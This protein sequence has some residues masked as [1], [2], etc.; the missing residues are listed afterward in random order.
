MGRTE[1]VALIEALQ[2]ARGGS[3]VIVYLTNTRDGIEANMA[4]DVVPQI[5]RH[6]QAAGVTK[7]SS[8]VD[9]V[10]HS[11]GG[12]GVVPWR[13]VSL[14]RE[15]AAEFTVLVPNRAYSAATLTA[16]G[17]DTVLMHPMGMLGPI[18]PTVGTVFNP[19]NPDNPSQKLGISVED[20]SSY[21]A[22][23]RD[24]VGIRH[25]EELVQAFKLLAEKVHPLALGTV[26]RST[27][28]SRMLAERLMRSRKN[29][30][31]VD[32]HSIT[33][34]IEK[35]TSKLYFHGHPIHRGEARDELKLPYVLDAPDNVADA[36][37]ALFEAYS[38]EL[39][40]E[41]QFNPFDEATGG[42][43][44]I[45]LPTPPS[46][47]PN[48]QMV[49]SIPNVHRAAIGPVPHALVESVARS[50]RF[51]VSYDAVITREW[52]GTANANLSVWKAAWEEETTP[53]PPSA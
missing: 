3:T 13:L 22:L 50:D 16:L 52:N 42:G 29:G 18:D 30:P 53:V 5:Y 35:L 21:I 1:R 7:E 46:I 32:N 47:M 36:M 9:L 6:L 38:D 25:E 43:T 15:F 28:Q 19:T 49:P 41:R 20:V 34:I 2:V 31:T 51:L 44:P 17:A 12:D 26:K 10:I 39:K 37:W 23:V 11:N 4:M 40:L 24:D 33:E 48:G 27:S 45:A 14:I 8:R